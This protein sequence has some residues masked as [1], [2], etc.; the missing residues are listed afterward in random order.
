MTNL[1]KVRKALMKQLE[2]VETNK[3]NDSDV[4]NLVE[5]SNGVIK[6]YNVELRADELANNERVKEVKHGVYSEEYKPSEA[7]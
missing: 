7:D 3:H 5:V 1:Q 4:R 6:A 2:L